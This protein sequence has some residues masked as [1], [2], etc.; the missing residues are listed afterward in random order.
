MDLSSIG[1]FLAG[2][3]GI[4][5]AVVALRD[6]TSTGRAK[7]RSTFW[8]ETLE[9]N[10]LKLVDRE[11]II[12]AFRFELSKPYAATWAINRYSLTEEYFFIVSLLFL[13]YTMAV[14]AIQGSK[15]YILV[16]IIFILCIPITCMATLDIMSIR[17]SKDLVS[18][19][20]IR[21]KDVPEILDKRELRS[22]LKKSW[23]RRYYVNLWMALIPFTCLSSGIYL[24]SCLVLAYLNSVPVSEPRLYLIPVSCIFTGT[25]ISWRYFHAD[26]KRAYLNQTL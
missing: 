17:F 13:N 26:M 21:E 1:S 25:I 16:I 12:Q 9:S 10:S 11:K 6:F 2:A 22:I 7:R 3:T 20:F 4:A 18:T 15:V 14:S 5:G 23:K 8:R 19:L 24:F